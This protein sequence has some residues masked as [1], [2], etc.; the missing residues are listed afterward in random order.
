M[1][2]NLAT[3]LEDTTLKDIRRLEKEIGYPILAF[4]FYD[5]Q[6]AEL[7]DRKLAKI[8]E[9]EKN[10]CVCLLAVKP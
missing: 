8:Q 6:P 5:L 4:S 10:K 3:N 1:F 7:D 9:Y 2:T